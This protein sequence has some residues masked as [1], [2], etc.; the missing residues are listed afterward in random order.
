M[1]RFLFAAGLGAA[2]GYLLGSEAG[3]AKLDRFT[4]RAR[5]V[6]TDPGMQQKVSNI[7]GQVRTTAEKLPDPVGGVVKNAASQVQTKLDHSTESVG[8]AV[9]GLGEPGGPTSSLGE[10]GG[11]TSSLGEF[12]LG[13]TSSEQG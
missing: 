1:K 6:A 13:E 7:A 9:S 5:E 8:D 12:G 4:S 11:P 2:V 3:R 10:P